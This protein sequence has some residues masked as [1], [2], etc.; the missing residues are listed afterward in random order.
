[1]NPAHSPEVY[2][3]F[4]GKLCKRNRRHTQKEHLARKYC[5]P[6]CSLLAKRPKEI[7]KN[8]KYCDHPFKTTRKNQI[9]CCK[10]CLKASFREK[11]NKQITKTCRQ[12]GKEFKCTL[13]KTKFTNCVFCSNECCAEHQRKPAGTR[14]KDDP[15]R[16]KDW[17]LKS[18]YGIRVEDYEK[19]LA[20]QEG[21]CLIC[22]KKSESLVID[23]D[24][25]TGV[26]RGLLCHHCNIGLG[27]LKDNANSLEAAI[28]YLR[29]NA[30]PKT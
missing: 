6:T 14:A 25:N 3:Q 16:V 28:I 22:G 13:A 7:I 26:V 1:M 9:Y 4:C 27:F 12:C 29:G 21:K 23:H 24:H 19:M 15:R 18:Q 10:T 17:Q 5:S 30:L 2:C 8:C 20:Q 11:F